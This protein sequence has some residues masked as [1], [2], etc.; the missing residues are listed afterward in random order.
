MFQLKRSSAVELSIEQ[1]LDCRFITYRPN[2]LDARSQS[3]FIGSS[4][5]R[6]RGTGMEFAELR[7][8][9]PGDDIRHID[10]RV[11]ARTGKVHSK[12]FHE[13]RDRPVTIIVDLGVN[14]FFGSQAKIKALMACELA[15]I[16]GWSSIN[17][18]QR[19]G[20]TA[21][22][23]TV[24][25]LPFVQN[26]TRWAAQLQHLC[27][28]YAQQLAQLQQLEMMP[29]D[30]QETL[31]HLATGTSIHLV[32]DFYHYSSDDLAFL[33]QIAL[34]HP[35]RL[36]QISDPLEFILPKQLS[37]T[38][39]VSQLHNHGLIAPQNPAFAETYHQHALDRQAQLQQQL[40]DYAI[41]FY[42]LSTAQEWN[43]Y[44]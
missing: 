15:A 37:G 21:L 12:V 27:A 7:Q 39:S 42:Q 32:S 33:G 8:Y 38:L 9:N 1:L 23:Q 5:S 28:N 4:T 3:Q 29:I 43:E 26:Q 25:H 10:W 22:A 17:L 6:L 13:E 18:H 2:V 20:L 11:S 44:F 24:N 35:L 19:T 36:W 34:H 30:L 40:G 31:G 14:M 41:P 16:I